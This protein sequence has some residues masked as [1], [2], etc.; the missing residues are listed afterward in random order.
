MFPKLWEKTV[1]KGINQTLYLLKVASGAVNRYSFIVNQ[2]NPACS[3][4][5]TST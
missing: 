4:R 2:K 5:V 1:R 3:T